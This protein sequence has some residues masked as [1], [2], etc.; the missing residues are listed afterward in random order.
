M[1]DQRGLQIVLFVQGPSEGV[2]GAGLEHRRFGVAENL[3]GALVVVD[4]CLVAAG[5]SVGDG[6]VAQ[7]IGLP[8]SVMGQPVL[9]QGA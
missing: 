9:L 1:L 4:R 8:G 3:Q 2:P 7:R 5:A 6:E